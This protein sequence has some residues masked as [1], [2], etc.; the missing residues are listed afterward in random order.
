M[1]RDKKASGGTMRFVLLP[2]LGRAELVDVREEMVLDLL[3]E[4]ELS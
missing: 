4:E 3:K 2:K 1:K